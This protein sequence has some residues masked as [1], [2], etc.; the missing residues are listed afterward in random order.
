MPTFER[1][2]HVQLALPAGSED[3]ARQ[4]Y[5]GALR[6]DELPKPPELAKRG[7]VWFASG[8]VRVHL[9]VDPGF[10]AA[11]KAHPAFRCGDYHGLLAQLQAAGIAVVR[12]ELPFEGKQHCYV[13]DPF[14]NRIELI[15]S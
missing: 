6:L 5:A 10:R 7:G 8:D 2:D 12:D 3:A 9:G 11:K 4:F 1:I 14:G 15:E 13:C